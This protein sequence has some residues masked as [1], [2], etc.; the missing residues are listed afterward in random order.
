MHLSAFDV[1]RRRFEVNFPSLPPLQVVVG[2][3]F[4]PRLMSSSGMHCSVHIPQGVY[5]V[6]TIR[7]IMSTKTELS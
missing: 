6:I 3:N 1:P 7:V 4:D 2:F 5:R